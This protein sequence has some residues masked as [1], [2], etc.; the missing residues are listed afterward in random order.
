MPR[1]Y[2]GFRGAACACIRSVI[3]IHSIHTNRLLPH[4]H[5][6]VDARRRAFGF[7]IFHAPARPAPQRM[8]GGEHHLVAARGTNVSCWPSCQYPGSLHDQEA[9]RRSQHKA[10]LLKPT[11]WIGKLTLY[12]APAHVLSGG[13]MIERPPRMQLVLGSN[14]GAAENPPFTC[15]RLSRVGPLDISE[16]L[17]VPHLIHSAALVI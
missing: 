13:E 4:F 5:E 14:A 16:G 1:T 7:F 9:W 15:V 8:H 11:A 12:Q 2:H 17:S 3:R 6:A 10:F